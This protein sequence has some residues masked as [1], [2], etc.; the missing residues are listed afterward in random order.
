[1][2]AISAVMRRSYFVAMF[3][4]LTDVAHTRTF[5]KPT[6]VTTLTFDG[7]LDEATAEAIWA[8]MESTDDADQAR[9]AV[10][11][12]DRDV[13]A[14]DDPVRRLYDYMLGDE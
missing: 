14:A 2:T 13:L 7:D 11:R 1:M 3:A 10:L 12:A 6:G 9:R 4:D 5:D 8:R